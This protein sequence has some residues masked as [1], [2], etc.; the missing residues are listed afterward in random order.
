MGHSAKEIFKKYLPSVYSRTLGKRKKK[1]K[2]LFAEC[3]GGGS[4]ANDLLFVKCLPIPHHK[5]SANNAELLFL[6]NKKPVCQV[7]DRKL[8]ANMLAPH[9]RTPSPAAPRCCPASH[10]EP[11]PPPAPAI[12]WRRGG[13]GE[14]EYVRRREGGGKEKEVVKVP[15]PSSL[16]LTDISLPLSP[17]PVLFLALPSLRA[18]RA[19]P[20]IG[21]EHA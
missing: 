18:R 7:L 8:L 11:P 20:L 3:R 13:E 15:Q 5:H 4:L 19:D 9:H 16:C 12:G 1:I 21:Y 6:K 17:D 10:Q 14:Q 2:N